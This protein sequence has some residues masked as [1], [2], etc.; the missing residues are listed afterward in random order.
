LTDLSLVSLM[1]GN[2]GA[3]M[4]VA[5]LARAYPQVSDGIVGFLAQHGPR[6]TELWSRFKDDYGE[7]I[8]AF[9]CDL[10]ARMSEWHV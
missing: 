2:P 3:T 7:D 8:V 10:L 4:V 9:G 5:S 6:G 1:E